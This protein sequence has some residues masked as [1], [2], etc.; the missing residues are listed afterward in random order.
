[1]ARRRVTFGE[2][3]RRATRDGAVEG[4]GLEGGSTDSLVGAVLTPFVAVWY[5]IVG[6]PAPDADQDAS[7]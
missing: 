1:M 6:E 3:W 7:R 4:P 5:W 2:S